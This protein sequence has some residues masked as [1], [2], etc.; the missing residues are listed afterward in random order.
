MLVAPSLPS[1]VQ[2]E[3]IQPGLN[4]RRESRTSLFALEIPTASCV[5]PKTG[6]RGVKVYATR[7][8]RSLGEGVE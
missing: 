5:S 7:L 1:S 4:T 2:A 3:M 8:I 6:Y